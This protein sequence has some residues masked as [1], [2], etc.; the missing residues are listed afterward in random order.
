MA[1]YSMN[2]RILPTMV[3]GIPRSFGLRTRAGTTDIQADV[4]IHGMYV[5]HIDGIK[6]LKG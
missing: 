2:I 1:W 3:F 5:L 4:Y 6:S